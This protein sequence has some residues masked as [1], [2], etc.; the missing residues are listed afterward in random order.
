MGTEE[1][2]ACFVL[3]PFF[4]EG[5]GEGFRRD[6]DTIVVSK[7]RSKGS[8]TVDGKTV[9]GGSDGGDIHCAYVDMP[10]GPLGWWLKYLTGYVRLEK[11][12]DGSRVA[13]SLLGEPKPRQSYRSRSELTVR[14]M[15]DTNS[16]I[17]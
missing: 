4:T 10:G 7:E 13:F 3:P 14:T 1:A 8:P 12:F 9:S 11:R 2:F 16:G 5:G 6:A 17:N 15:D